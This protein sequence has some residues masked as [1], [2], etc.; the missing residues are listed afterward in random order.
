VSGLFSFLPGIILIVILIV[1]R[2]SPVP[3]IAA[4]PKS[5]NTKAD[6]PT[7]PG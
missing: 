6:K 7:L 1:I 3:P 2:H 5:N 4:R